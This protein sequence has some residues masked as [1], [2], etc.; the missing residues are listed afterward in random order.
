MTW[1]ISLLSVT[2]EG[3]SLGCP[4]KKTAD[5]EI[6]R[7]TFLSNKMKHGPLIIIVQLKPSHFVV[8][9]V[10]ARKHDRCAFRTTAARQHPSVQ[11]T[12]PYGRRTITPR[13]TAFYVPQGWRSPPPISP[14]NTHVT[15]NLPNSGLSF[16][17]EGFDF[18]LMFALAFPNSVPFR[19]VYFGLYAAGFAYDCCMK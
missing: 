6:C 3:D 4:F 1:S 9:P 18:K 19:E 16:P 8:R 10:I 7:D 5:S 2:V 15:R 17:D 11:H 14:P 13:P 12:S